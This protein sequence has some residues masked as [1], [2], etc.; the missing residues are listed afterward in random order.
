MYRTIG[1]SS[2]SE[3]QTQSE[4]NYNEFAI[5]KLQVKRDKQQQ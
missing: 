3:E 5:Y 1:G 4:L 2:K